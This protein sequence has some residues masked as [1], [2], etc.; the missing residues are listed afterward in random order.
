MREVRGEDQSD[1]SA[2]REEAHH[3]R[4]HFAWD[5]NIEGLGRDA[6]RVEIDDVGGNRAV[7]DEKDYWDRQ[8]TE[9]LDHE[10]SGIRGAVHCRQTR[11][12]HSEPHDRYE[13]A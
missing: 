7:N 4:Q 11:T 1:Y 3:N 9:A 5:T 8:D 12:Q 2:H 10:F 13:L 6:E